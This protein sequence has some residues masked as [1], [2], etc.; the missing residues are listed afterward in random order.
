MYGKKKQKGLT[1][2]RRVDITDY[3][4]EFVMHMR[5]TQGRIFDRRHPGE[6]ENMKQM[7]N[8]P[9]NTTFKSIRD[10]RDGDYY[11]HEQKVDYVRSNLKRGFIFYFIC[12]ACGRRAR[13]LYEYSSLESPLCRICCRLNYEQPG[14]KARE[15]S[16]LIRR[17]YLS[18][19]AKHILIRR[20]GITSDDITSAYS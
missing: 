14:R 8:D 2:Q 9:R 13:Y 17:P 4:Q 16:R 11:W 7:M 19:E 18:T 3:V 1:V 12:N 10:L 20:A 6:A 5:R 15:I